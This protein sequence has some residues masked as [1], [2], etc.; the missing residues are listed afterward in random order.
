MPGTILVL[1]GSDDGHSDIVI[2]VLKQKGVRVV[3]FH[4]ADFPQDVR[5]AAKIKDGTIRGHF[6]LPGECVDL[7]EIVSVW[8]RRPESPR[9]PNWDVAVRRFARR[10]AKEAL[11]GLWQSLDCFWVSRPD[12]IDAASSKAPQLLWAKEVGFDVPDTLITNEPSEV[13]QFHEKHSGHVVYKAL[14]LGTIEYDEYNL[15]LIYTNP[16]T[17]QSAKHFDQVALMPCQ[18]QEYVPKEIEVRAT[19]FGSAVL[20]VEIHSQ[21]TES[22]KHDWRRYD[23]KTPHY[24]HR[25]PSAVEKSCIDLVKLLGLEFGAI[26]LIVRP[27]GRYVFLEINPNGQWAWLEQLTGL[28]FVETFVDLL[29]T[30]GKSSRVK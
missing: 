10:E 1:T 8:Y 16:I 18:F 12:K 24:P 11:A 29:L 22:T 25:L 3:R 13:R 15:G 14:S 27:D 9:I 21:V 17:V 19:V 30:G 26:D 4:T 28:P 2:D 5:M 6:A 7:E 20:S 23:E